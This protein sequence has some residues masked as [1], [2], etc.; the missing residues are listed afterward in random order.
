FPEGFLHETQVIAFVLS[1]DPENNPDVLAITGASTALYLSPIPFY[2]PIAAVRVGLIDE[3]FVVNPTFAQ[4]KTSRL[5]LI[6][7]GSRDAIVM[8]EA[9]AKEV[10][11][12][13]MVEALQ[14]AH[15]HIKEL[16][17]MQ[18]DMFQQRRPVKR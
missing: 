1:A 6:V 2:N 7:V 12:E 14:F 3:Q 11:E 17:R 13:R 16:V 5:N 10:T 4:L 9:G 15:V 8:V 18:E